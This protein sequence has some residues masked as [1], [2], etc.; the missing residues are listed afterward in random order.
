MTS[1]KALEKLLNVTM[2]YSDWLSAYNYKTVIEKDLELLEIYK[3]MFNYKSVKKF[4]N[5][6]SKE[7]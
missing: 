5:Y 2:P 1:K 3:K 4:I 6:I 7:K